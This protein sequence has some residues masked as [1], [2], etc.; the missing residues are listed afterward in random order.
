MEDFSRIPA[1]TKAA[2]MQIVE[3]TK[4][5]SGWR[6]YRTLT[7]LGLPRSVYYAWKKRETLEDRAGK[8]CRVYELL[9]EER[10]A[11]CDYALQFPKI[12][13]RKLT[14]MM[15]D[16]GVACVGESTVYRVLSDAD[17]LSRWKRSVVSSGEYNFRPKAPNQQWHTDVMYVW[18]AARFYFLLSFVDAYSRYIVHH[19][20]LI[21]LDGKSV[22]TELQAALESVQGA[23]PPRVVHDHG[24]EFVN[25]D[26][27]AVIKAHNL[28]DIKTKPRHPESNG[29]VERFNGTVRDETNND[30]G[31]NYLQAEAI[32]AK[33]MRH[34]NEE[35][36]HAALG[37]MQ[38]AIWHR[39]Q[40][41]EVRDE[42]A[43]RI[44]AART[45]RKSINQQRFKQAA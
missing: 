21:S 42:R 36:L 28:I 31:N 8:P 14:W 16:A 40:P 35:R 29:I 39:G 2:V 38:P 5:R 22:A 30:Y 13:Y 37:Y 18:V 15:V 27:S 11:I 7:A 6:V 44:A 19:K 17:L 26:V 43:R 24:G 32:I 25:R 4:K 10:L 23:K 1:E 45:N 9:P 12:G 34:Y 33:L 41:E 20:L 3:Q